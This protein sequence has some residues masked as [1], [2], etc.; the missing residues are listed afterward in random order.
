MPYLIILLLFFASGAQAWNGAGHRLVA[1]LAWQEMSPQA[2]HQASALLKAHPDYARWLKRQRSADPAEG[3]FLEAATWPDDIRNDRRFY[4]SGKTPTPLL[5]GFPHMERHKNWHFAEPAAEG[6][7]GQLDE[8]LTL[9]AKDLQNGAAPARSYALPWFL[10]LV[11][12]LHQPLHTGGR[13]DG[14]GNGYEVEH[15]L[16]PRKPFMSLHAYW[17]DLPGPPW[18]RGK[19][20]AQRLAR[21]QETE[22]ARE[23]QKVGNVS[24]WLDE[25][26]A[27]LA[28]GVYPETEG[29]LLPLVTEAFDQQARQTADQ[30]LLRAGHRLGAWLNRLLVPRETGNR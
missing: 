2:R 30:Q 4:D 1:A 18:L 25:S 15:S 17:D 16:N 23:A 10:H 13:R 14:G 28:H 26:R 24:G 29:S 21:L 5:T 6:G 19:Q 20:L 8:R 27:L 11:A 7:A 9:L 22:T 3:V 12:D